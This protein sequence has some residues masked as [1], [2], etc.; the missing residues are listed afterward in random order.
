MRREVDDPCPSAPCAATEVPSARSGTIPITPSSTAA[1]PLVVGQVLEAAD[2]A[3]PDRVDQHVEF[4]ARTAGPTRRRARRPVRLSVTS[5]TSPTASG[6]PRPVRL[7]DRLVENDLEC[8]PTMATRAP[9]SARHRAVASPI[10]RPPPTTIAVASLK[11]RSMALHTVSV[12]GAAVHQSDL[13]FER[14]R[15]C[16]QRSATIPRKAY[17]RCYGR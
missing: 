15:V 17:Y 1:T 7:L 5:A 12:I 16:L 8:G 6:L 11:P 4:A 9:S 2:G 13:T 3:R 10:P 14:A